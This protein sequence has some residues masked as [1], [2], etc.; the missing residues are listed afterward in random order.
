[1]SP[2]TIRYSYL[3]QFDWVLQVVSLS[4]TFNISDTRFSEAMSLNVV[5][6]VIHTHII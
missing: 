5:D 2:Y 3:L 4:G 1:M 6:K